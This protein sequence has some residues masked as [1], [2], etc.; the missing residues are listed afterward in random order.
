MSVG[1]LSV[2]ENAEE[3]R[4][5]D[6][7]LVLLVRVDYRLELRVDSS[8]E[9]SIECILTRRDHIRMGQCTL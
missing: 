5:L 6:L 4:S 3:N 1:L 9:R 2:L 8:K 7:V